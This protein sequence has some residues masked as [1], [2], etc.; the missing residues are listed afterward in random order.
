MRSD[1]REAGSSEEE[2]EMVWCICRAEYYH[3]AGRP[4]QPNAESTAD[5]Q[6]KYNEWVEKHLS[7]VNKATL[8]VAKQRHGSTGNVPLH[9]QSEITKFTSPNMRDYSDYG[10]E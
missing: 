10:M 8:I 4:D 7:L 9:F 6:A 1:L 5:Q 2:G 3:D